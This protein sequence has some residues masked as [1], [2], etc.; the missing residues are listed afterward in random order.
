M[1]EKK[2]PFADYLSSILGKEEAERISNMSGEEK[3]NRLIVITGRSGITGK[4]TL[5]RLLIKH[6]YQV[7]ELQDQIKINLDRIIEHPIINFHSLVD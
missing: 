2:I 1:I 3:E 4:S 6:G 7:L 5:S